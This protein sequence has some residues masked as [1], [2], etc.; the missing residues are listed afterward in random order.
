MKILKILKLKTI[1]ML[2]RRF[3]DQKRSVGKD[4]DD[5]EDF[6]NG[7]GDVSEGDE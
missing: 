2:A 6:P 4:G 5:A 1:M 3:A 7:N